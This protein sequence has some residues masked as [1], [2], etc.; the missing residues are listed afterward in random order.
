MSGVY[1]GRM[2]CI[3]FIKKNYDMLKGKRL[4]AVAVGL[5]DENNLWS[6]INYFFIPS[7]IKSNIKY[8]KILGAYKGKS[9][10]KKPNLGK[11]LD[12]IKSK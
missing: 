3:D 5:L 7:K 10:V 2:E 1:A 6:R 9:F 11:I 12:Y 8:F 4:A